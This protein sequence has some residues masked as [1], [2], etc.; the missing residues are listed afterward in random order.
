MRGNAPADV[1]Q[2]FDRQ[3]GTSGPDWDSL[4]PAVAGH[5]ADS[6]G[7]GVA[8]HCGRRVG[9]VIALQPE[10]DYGAPCELRSWG[11]G[12]VGRKCV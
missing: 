1:A 2:T 8:R 10:V 7:R 12:F 4:R 9:G 6:M 5:G 11:R 3:S